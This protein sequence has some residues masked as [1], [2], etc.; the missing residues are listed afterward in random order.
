[1]SR[2][3]IEMISAIASSTTERVLEKGALN[4][5]TPRSDAVSRSIWLVPMQN[6][7]I[8]TRLSAASSTR[9]VTWVL[10]RMPSRATPATAPD[11]LVLVER[12]RSG[13]DVEARGAQQRFGVGV[14]LLEQEGARCGGHPAILRTSPNALRPRIGRGSGWITTFTGSKWNSQARIMPPRRLRPVTAR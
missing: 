9:W 1:M 4:T 5:V 3:V 6:A 12:T 8:A 7:P 10:E 2:R 14:D 11:Q 13:L